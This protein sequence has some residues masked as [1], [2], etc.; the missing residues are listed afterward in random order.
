MRSRGGPG[1]ENRIA[2]PLL[3]PA[4][5]FGRK[6]DSGLD[7]KPIGAHTCPRSNAAPFL[8]ARLRQSW[9][10]P[11]IRRSSVF[12]M[13]TQEGTRPTGIGRVGRR[14]GPGKPHAFP[15]YKELRGNW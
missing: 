15:T 14:G 12:R 10:I 11:L 9:E 13:E 5:R 1:S 2:L 8:I 6:P 4:K 3:G 7:T